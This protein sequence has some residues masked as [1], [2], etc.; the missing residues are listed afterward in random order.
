MQM[1]KK[2][3]GNQDQAYR[4][5]IKTLLPKEQIW[6]RSAVK[7]VRGDERFLSL[8]QTDKLYY[9]RKW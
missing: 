8:A 2:I 7:A 3:A 4:S 9:E 6:G 5:V 1:L